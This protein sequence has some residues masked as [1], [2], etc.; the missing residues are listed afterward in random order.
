MNCEDFQQLLF[1]ELD[2]T[3]SSESQ[4]EFEQHLRACKAC[5]EFQL[6]NRQFGEALSAHFHQLTEG[7]ALSPTARCRVARECRVPVWT[8]HLATLGRRVYWRWGFAGLAFC[9]V[10][11]FASLAFKPGQAPT[12]VAKQPALVSISAPRVVASYTFRKEGRLVVDTLVFRTNVLHESVW[13]QNGPK[14]PHP[15]AVHPQPL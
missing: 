4:R 11:L 1:D 5:R 3:L 12:R 9:A 10:V 7:L 13:A 8:E 2:G 14:L 6:H 15:N